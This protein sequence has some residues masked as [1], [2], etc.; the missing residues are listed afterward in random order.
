MLCCAVPQVDIWALGISAIEMAEQ[1]P[2]RWKINPNRV[3]FMIVKDPPPRLADKDRWS[4]TIQGFVGQCLQKDARMRPTAKYLRQHKFAAREH[5]AAIKMLLP[6]I[7]QARKYMAA[8]AASVPPPDGLPVGDDGYFSWQEPAATVAASRPPTSAG[9]AQQVP[10]GLAAYQQTAH[11]ASPFPQPSDGVLSPS[12]AT[13]ASGTI[14]VRDSA[15]SRVWGTLRH[16]L[17]SSSSD[18]LANGVFGCQWGLGYP[19]CLWL[20]YAVGGRLLC[21]VWVMPRG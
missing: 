10:A 15:E 13:E 20:A 3:I 1:F 18:K 12:V 19:L 16:G 11:A 21:L 6:M 8:T 17:P 5:A 14:I 7:Q 2:P 9:A 4:L